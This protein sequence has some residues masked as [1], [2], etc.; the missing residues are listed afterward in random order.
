MNKMS[1]IKKDWVIVDEDGDVIDI[2]YNITEDDACIYFEE[3]VNYADFDKDF[4]LFEK[5]EWEAMWY[6]TD[7]EFEI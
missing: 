5:E 7:Y 6:D 2:M 1:K 4:Q 3:L